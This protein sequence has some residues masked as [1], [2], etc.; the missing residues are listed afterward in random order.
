M[1]LQDRLQKGFFAVTVEIQPAVD[2]EIFKLLKDLGCLKGRVDCLNI[3]ELRKPSPEIDSL[4][5]GK[6]LMDQRFDAIYQTSTR[7]KHRPNLAADLLK[8]HQ[9]GIDNILVFSEDYT[10]TGES[11]EEKMFFHVDS[12]KLFSVLEHLGDGTDLKGHS[13]SSPVSFNIGSGADASKGKKTPTQE[14]RE[15]EQM[16]EHGTR[17]FQTSPVFD[18]DSLREFMRIV[19]PFGVSVLAGVVL[20]RNGEM[21]RFIQKHLHIDIPDWIIEKMTNAPDKLKASVEIFAHLVDGFRDVCQGVH[22]IPLGWYSKLPKFMDAA[23]LY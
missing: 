9:L 17:F 3:S 1:S 14:L 16:V 21:A 6:A 12:A 11:R 22:I 2:D 23:K 8:A 7:Q 4:V 13:L 19:E 18:L 15:M 10:L 5:T 20:L